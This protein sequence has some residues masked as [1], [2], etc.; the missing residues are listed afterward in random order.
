MRASK[1]I[2]YKYILKLKMQTTTPDHF[3]VARGCKKLVEYRVVLHAGTVQNA[4]HTHTHTL[5]CR[6][7]HLTLKLL[8]AIE[9]Q[10][11][12]KAL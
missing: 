11:R 6:L 1:R 12:V 9:P 4:L 3:R 7:V 5:R 8:P 2:I 10:P